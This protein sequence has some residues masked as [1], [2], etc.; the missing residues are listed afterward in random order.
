[1]IEHEFESKLKELKGC[2]REYILDNIEDVKENAS[3][4]LTFLCVHHEEKTPSMHLGVDHLSAHCFGCHQSSNIFYLH[5]QLKGAPLSGREFIEDNFNPLA[6]M[7]GIEPIE[8]E[9]LSEDMLYRLKLKQIYAAVYKLLSTSN[10]DLISHKY[11]DQLNFK[12]EVCYSMGVG[13]VLNTLEFIESL[14]DI[15][16]WTSDELDIAGIKPYL[17]GP[18]KI[19]YTLFDNKGAPVALASRNLDYDGKFGVPLNSKQ[20]AKWINSTTSEI[21]QKS[22]CLYGFHTA[23]KGNTRV[24]YIV[25]GQ[26]DVCNAISHGISNCVS[27]GS[28]SLTNAQIGLIIQGNFTEVIIALDDDLAGQKGAD[29]AI[30]KLS[31]IPGLKPQVLKVPKTYLL[32]GSGNVTS[33]P[34][35]YIRL[36]GADAFLSLKPKSAFKY[37]IDSM[38]DTL[39]GANQK[40]AFMQKFLPIIIA[41]NSA[42][43]QYE[44]R[45]DIANRIDVLPEIIKESQ[46]RLERYQNQESRAQIKKEFKKFSYKLNDCLDL[47]HSKVPEV[48]SEFND[49]VH[50]MMDSNKHYAIGPQEVSEAFEIWK[51]ELDKASLQDNYWKTGMPTWD[52]QIGGITKTGNYTGI[53]GPANTGKS[54]LIM[55]LALGVLQNNDPSELLMLFWTIDDPRTDVLYKLTAILSNQLIADVKNYSLSNKKKKKEI[56]KAVARLEKWINVDKCLLIKDM[57]IGTT[58]NDCQRWVN[59]EQQR[60]PHKTILLIIDNFANM[61]SHKPSV[62]ESQ[63]DCMEKLHELRVQKNM[64]ILSSLEVNKEASVGRSGNKGISGASTIVYRQTLIASLY[65]EMDDFKNQNKAEMPRMVWKDQY[66]HTK[67]IIEFAITKTKL[68]FKVE[69]LPKLYF[70]F[71]NTVALTNEI[72]DRDSLDKFM[73]ENEQGYHRDLRWKFKPKITRQVITPTPPRKMIQTVALTGDSDL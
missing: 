73:E 23:V 12:S 37:T 51:T 32:D 45:R 35:N 44:M 28:S 66:G 6:I 5:N 26:A 68:T 52:A 58:G 25:E 65:N 20:K 67:P 24:I 53:A 21:Y 60:N 9:A 49:F 41:E 71:C 39:V 61:T 72:G 59:A 22:E 57:A 42:I 18:T 13:T 48:T 62:L 43:T 46:D 2:I 30:K 15:G 7:Y 4:A 1:M 17:L 16:D 3:G 8:V 29:E 70:R 63:I 38:P 40:D 10:A 64:A 34:D 27:V 69:F 11:T 56:Q 47:D 14:R 33:D 54:A 50:N 36:N 19:T 55:N 31:K